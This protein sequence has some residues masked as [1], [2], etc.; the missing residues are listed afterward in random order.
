M[1]R[2]VVATAFVVAVAVVA[3]GTAAPGTDATK[4]ASA[5]CNALRAK[6]GAPAFAQAYPTFGRCVSSLAQV[7]QQNINS[8]QAACSSEQNDPTF[9][10]SHNGQTFDKFYGKGPK[11]KDAF[12]NCVSAKAKASSQAEQQGRPNPART[13]RALRTQLG[14]ALFAQSY[15]KNAHD[16]NAMGKCVSKTA[17]A[18]T[19]NELSAAATCRTE[20]GDA[21]FPAAHGAKTFAQFYGTN[22]LSNA[23]GKC[24]SAKASVAAQAQQQATAAAAK[25]CMSE[26][27]AD[28]AQFK[29]NYGTF[30]RCVSLHASGH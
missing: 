6:M 17:H 12:G 25:R 7:E 16:R 13:C 8:A 20:Q 9:A 19:Q 1:K 10:V 2:I 28:A 11:G 22:D 5:A 27:K 3:A 14:A 18:Q 4:N 21:A 24:V 23:F 29:T 30:G 26:Q 15:G